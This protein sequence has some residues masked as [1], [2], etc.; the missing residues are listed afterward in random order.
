MMMWPRLAIVVAWSIFL[1]FWIVKSRSVKV[2]AE[3][4]SSRQRLTYMA[5]TL[6][7]AALLIL[8]SRKPD[9]ETLLTRTLWPQTPVIQWIAAALVFAGLLLTLRARVVLGRNWSAHVVLKE[10]HEL[11]TNGPY[12][13]VRHPIY[14]G[15][16]LMLVGS[17][18]I[19]GTVASMLGFAFVILGLL[20]KLGQEEAIMLR[21]F[22]DTY[23]AY[24][25]QVK[26]LIPFVW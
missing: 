14:T 6:I 22:P 25:Q 21:Q 20:I 17:A 26:R 12:A 18:V 2:T 1:G 24:R 15:L 7:G 9:V 5:P 23:P 3:R 13:L 16:L 10:D 11:V 4:A 8:G 19:V